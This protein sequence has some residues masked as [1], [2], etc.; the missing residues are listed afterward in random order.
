[1]LNSNNRVIAMAY[2]A[3]LL[4]ALV[5][6]ASCDGDLNVPSKDAST[7]GA[8]GGGMGSNAQG[9][10]D[11]G[12]GSSAA[13]S[14]SAGGSEGSGGAAMCGD[15]KVTGSETCDIGSDAGPMDGCV[16][17]EIQYG[18]ICDGQPSK[19]NKIVINEVYYSANP[20]D[21]YI[22]LYSLQP[23]KLDTF[24]LEF[25]TTNGNI[26]ASIQLIGETNKNNLFVIKGTGVNLPTEDA[27]KF[28]TSNQ[29][30]IKDGISTLHTSNKASVRLINLDLGVVVDSLA[31]GSFDPQVMEISRGEGDPFTSQMLSEVSLSR[32]PH[33]LDSD[34]NKD[35]FKCSKK[36][37][38][39]KNEIMNCL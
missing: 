4:G 35:D 26:N 28:G 6:I 37:V 30:E 12:G 5:Q 27:N 9:G 15:G 18:F 29:I 34:N 32:V 3:V 17:C 8:G 20:E 11:Q 33:G 23:T 25:F 2:G 14:S 38:G 39:L 31:Y 7:A 16:G 1:M 19:C 22:E 24:A 13:Q 21:C 36:T 10:N